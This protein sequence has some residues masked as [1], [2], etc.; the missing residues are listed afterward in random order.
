M[1]FHFVI[2]RDRKRAVASAVR[3]GAKKARALPEEPDKAVRKEP[4]RKVA[5]KRM[6]VAGGAGVPVPQ[7]VW[8]RNSSVTVSGRGGC[9]DTAVDLVCGE[10]GDSVADDGSAAIL[11]E[12]AS[13][14]RG[15]GF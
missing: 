15:R 10:A 1:L 7:V 2:A 12:I 14:S 9:A 8:T 5:G 13:I 3:G 6:S 4:V 11:A